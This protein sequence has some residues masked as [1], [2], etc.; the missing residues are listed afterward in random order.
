MIFVKDGVINVDGNK[1]NILKEWCIL[2]DS[3]FKKA[4]ADK[5]AEKLRQTT[6][7]IIEQSEELNKMKEEK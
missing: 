1:H 5:Y 3:I 4:F 7:F 6:E 2:T